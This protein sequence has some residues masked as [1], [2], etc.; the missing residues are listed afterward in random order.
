MWFPAMNRAKDYRQHFEI[1]TKAKHPEWGEPDGMMHYAFVLG[2][3][4]EI[5]E[6]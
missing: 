5:E 1:R 4:V 3:R 2:D 6:R